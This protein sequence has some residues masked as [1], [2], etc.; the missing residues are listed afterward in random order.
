MI[1]DDVSSYL[2]NF[3]RFDYKHSNLASELAL[4]NNVFIYAY[5]T[6]LQLNGTNILNNIAIRM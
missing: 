6:D 5:L 2:M 3:F 1:F 4:I